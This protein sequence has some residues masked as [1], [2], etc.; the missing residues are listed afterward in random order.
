[1][2]AIFVYGSLNM[3]LSIEVD[4]FPKEGETL[5]GRHFMQSG[6]GKGANQAVAASLAGAKTYLVGALG[7]D[8]FGEELLQDVKAYGVHEE[9]IVRKDGP[10]GCALI[11]L[12]KGD[13]RIVINPGANGLLNEKDGG[14][15]GDNG[16]EGDFLIAQLEAPLPTVEAVLTSSHQQGL[17]TIFN[18]TPVK[19]LPNSLYPSLDL[20]VVNEVECAFYSGVTPEKEKDLQKAYQTLAKKGLK[21]LLVT[22]GKRGSIFLDD[23]TLL[24]ADPYPIQAIDTTGAGDTY[25]GYLSALLSEKKS[26]AEAMRYA[27]AASA[28][29]CTK[30]GAQKA[31]PSRKEVEAFLLQKN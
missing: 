1:M 10:T 14:F 9:G 23:K 28:L 13:N 12:E 19:E 29:A 5:T 20:L 22:L 11:L 26:M 17:Y 2:A 31:M 21:R 25:I 6:G 27:S 15:I 18:P 7:K 24:R 30:R 3:D 8:A 16:K 4:A